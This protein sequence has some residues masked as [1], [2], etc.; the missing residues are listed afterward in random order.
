[1]TFFANSGTTWPHYDGQTRR[2][3]TQSLEAASRLWKI[4]AALES[5][6]SRNISREDIIACADQLQEAAGIYGRIGDALSNATVSGLTPAELELAALQL[7]YR[8]GEDPFFDR[9]SLPIGKLYLDLSQRAL[10]LAS[11]VRTFQLSDERRP[12]EIDDLAPQVFLMMRQWE[13]LAIL[14]RVIAVLNRRPR[15]G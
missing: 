6:D 11:L 8:Y 12:H 1:M 15:A 9:S 13:A 2:A 3:G 5:G 7:P 4:F 14:G 10:I